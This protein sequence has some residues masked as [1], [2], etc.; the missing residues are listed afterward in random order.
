MSVDN[1]RLA[2]LALGGDQDAFKELYHRLSRANHPQHFKV[3]HQAFKLWN[4]MVTLLK[5]SQKKDAVYYEIT[6]AKKDAADLYISLLTEALKAAYGLSSAHLKFTLEHPEWTTLLIEFK[7]DPSIFVW[8]DA[9]VFEYTPYK[10]EM[11][12]MIFNQKIREYLELETRCS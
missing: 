10:H 4:R 8:I 3:P 2:V 5:H 1:T 9:R 11:E 6:T 7:K 12:L